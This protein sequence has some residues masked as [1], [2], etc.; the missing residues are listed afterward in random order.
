LQVGCGGFCKQFRTS[1]AGEIAHARGLKYDI[2]LEQSINCLAK[3]AS[4]SRKMVVGRLK[5]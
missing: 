4:G 5:F 1:Y 3:D 2:I